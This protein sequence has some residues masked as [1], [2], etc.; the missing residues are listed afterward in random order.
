MEIK[1]NNLMLM[2]ILIL[3]IVLLFVMMGCSFSCGRKEGF[4]SYFADNISN[5]Y[6]VDYAN[7]EPT[8]DE[9]NLRWGQTKK[10]VPVSKSTAEYSYPGLSGYVERPPCDNPYRDNNRAMYDYMCGN[11]SNGRMYQDQQDQPGQGQGQFQQMYQQQDQDPQMELAS[12][13][14]SDNKNKCEQDCLKKFSDPLKAKLY[15]DDCMDYC[16]KKYGKQN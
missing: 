3:G 2:L 9:F 7:I 15:L 14:Q 16:E 10:H 8:E 13:A 1:N 4:L 12:K 11:S 6:A 5:P